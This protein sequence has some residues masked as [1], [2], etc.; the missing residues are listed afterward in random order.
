MPSELFCVVCYVKNARISRL[1]S[2][3]CSFIMCSRSVDIDAMLDLSQVFVLLYV[4]PCFADAAFEEVVPS[5]L[6][7]FCYGL[8]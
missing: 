6:L 8:G 1:F 2:C 3:M 4:C 7:L 5:D